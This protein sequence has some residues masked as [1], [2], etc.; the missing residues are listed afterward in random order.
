PLAAQQFTKSDIATQPSLATCAA[1][2]GPGVLSGCYFHDV[3]STPNPD[4][5]TQ[6]QMPFLT[7]TTAVPCAGSATAAGTFT[8]TSTDPASNAE[9]CFG[10]QITVTGTGSNLTTTPNYYGVLSS[11]GNSSSPAFIATPGYDLATG[12]GTPNVYALVNAPQ[13]SGLSIQTTSLPQ[14][15]V[16][17]AYSAALTASGRVG[18][19][20]WSIATGNLPPGLTLSPSSGVISGNP[21]A[22]GVSN[23][24]VQVKD[25]ESTP[26]S[27]S[28]SFSITVVPAAAPVATTTVLSSS[29]S[30]PGVGMQVTLT[31]AVSAV[32]GVP[33]GTVTFYNGTASIGTGILVNGAATLTTSF[34]SL[35]TVTLTAVY[36]G[37][38]NFSP[39]TSAPLTVTIVT[40]GFT[41]TVNPA[42]V[43]VPFANPA[44]VTVTVTPQGGF[45]GPV[46]FACGTLPAYFSCGFATASVSFSSSGA[47]VNNAL[48]IHTA[49][50][51]AST[52]KPGSSFGEKIAILFWLPAFAGLAAGGRKRRLAR[53]LLVTLSF[54]CIWGTNG[55]GGHGDHQAP[56]GIYSVPINLTAS[57]AAGQTVTVTVSVE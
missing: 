43:T 6:Q 47:A 30:A 17:S 7:A 18:P 35:G 24:T 44:S 45:A 19:Y 20:S 37:A 4:P 25:G 55:C 13:W 1:Y 11:A 10:Y 41:A 14:G 39:S 33:T 51:T 2:L 22:A 27:A 40:P 38:A 49:I 54:G 28:A 48:T 46:N 5:A 57:G 8:D 36:G 26:A 16:G 50:T 21:T 12:L 29:P 3:S 9:N 42:S 15:Q 53:I 52:R 31:A 32:G 23:F 34:A 56:D